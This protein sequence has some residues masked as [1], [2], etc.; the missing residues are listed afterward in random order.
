MEAAE[1][2][3]HVFFAIESAPQLDDARARSVTLEDLVDRIREVAEWPRELLF[4]GFHLHFALHSAG[5]IR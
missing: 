1:V 4:G 2:R 5:Q 3:P